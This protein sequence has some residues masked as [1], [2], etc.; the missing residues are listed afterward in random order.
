MFERIIPEIVHTYDPQ[1]F[2]WPASPSS[3]GCRL[4][5]PND[6]NRGDVHYWAVWHGTGV[7]RLRK[8]FFRYASEFGASVPS[9]KPSKP[10]PGRSQGQQRFSYICEKHQRQ[11]GANGKIMGYMQTPVNILRFLH[12]YLCFTAFSSGCHPLRRGAFPPAGAAVWAG[13]LS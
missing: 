6:P 5:E 4:D 1:A 2:Y 13:D 8:Y 3:G 11:Y 10:S 7:F 12:F 9:L